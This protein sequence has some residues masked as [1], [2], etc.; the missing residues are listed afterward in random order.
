MS[1]W[2]DYMNGLANSKTKGY[3]G[4]LFTG[5]TGN[6]SG[7]SAE[8]TY[9]KNTFNDPTDKGELKKMFIAIGDGSAFADGGRIKGVDGP[10]LHKDKNGY[11]TNMKDAV[12]GGSITVRLKADAS[13]KLS[14]DGDPAQAVQ[15]EAGKGGW[16]DNNLGVSGEDIA[17]AAAIAAAVY[18]GGAA[19]GAWGGTAAAGSA[20][21]IAAANAAMMA[22]TATEAQLAI[23]TAAETSTAALG[24]GAIG[25][26]AALSMGN[27]AALNGGAE[28]SSLYSLGGASSGGGLT[29]PAYGGG[30]LSA[31]GVTGAT[32]STGST[33]TSIASKTAGSWLTEL[34]GSKTLGAVVDGASSFFDSGLGKTVLG[35]IGV[36]AAAENAKELAN[37][38]YNNEIDLQKMRDDTLLTTNAL[39]NKTKVDTNV[40]DNQTKVDTTKLTTQNALDQI[41]LTDANKIA[42]NKRYSDA[43]AGINP[44]IVNSHTLKR[45]DGSE[46]FNPDG[47]LKSPNK[48]IIGSVLGGG[49]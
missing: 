20:A 36:Y 24:A 8:S 26:T 46:V 6:E 7:K 4:S 25:D 1:A 29:M 45:F 49:I 10:E 34:T 3:T 13:G 39:D 11:F 38:R 28:G 30:T 22:G 27:V 37:N 18:T 43:V 31:T 35:G 5:Y 17:K 14:I 44:G 15:Y 16:L 19:L 9:G 23:L 42:A 21:E 47:T 12:H 2:D 40:L 41:S 32:A 48:G 33:L